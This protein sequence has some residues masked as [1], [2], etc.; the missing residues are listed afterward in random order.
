MEDGRADAGRPWESR[1]VFRPDTALR[2]YYILMGVLSLPAIFITLPIFLARYH[3]LRYRLDE[4][5]VWMRVGLLFRKE[6]NLTYRR[7][8]DVHVTRGLIQRWFGIS[9]VAIQTASGSAT[10]EITIEGVRDADALRDFLYARMRG[11]KDDHA[12]TPEAPSTG[13]PEPDEALV[14]LREVRD[15]LRALN[16]KPERQS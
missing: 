2:S 14:L 8:Q 5:G 4:H 13:E 1:D 3:T 10:A 11:A 6:S 12:A 9:S 7:I 15:A 16:E